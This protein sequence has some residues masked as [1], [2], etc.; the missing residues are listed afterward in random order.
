[1]KNLIKVCVLALLLSSCATQTDSKAKER[2][3]G[4]HPNPEIQ[5]LK[6]YL[7]TQEAIDHVIS[8]DKLWVAKDFEAMRGHFVDTLKVTNWDGVTFTN[9]DAF[10]ASQEADSAEVSWTFDYA[11]SVDI[12][13]S[14]GGEHVQAGFTV[15][16][17]K[18]DGTV[19]KYLVHESY[20]IIDQKIVTLSQYK[21]AATQ[22]EE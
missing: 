16:S 6:W 13:P 15:S 2:M 12:N 9:F 18:E 3:I 22:S 11:Y 1:M 14:M 8:L 10:K 20:Y 19:E 5:D 4:F 21:Q 7:G 17:P